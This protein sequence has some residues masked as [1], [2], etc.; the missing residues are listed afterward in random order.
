MSE[1]PV[2]ALQVAS[3]CEHLLLLEFSLTHVSEAWRVDILAKGQYTCFVEV[4]VVSVSIYRYDRSEK[5]A[6]ERQKCM[7]SLMW[8]QA[9]KLSNKVNSSDSAIDTLSDQE[10]KIP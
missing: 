4:K 7:Y 6:F 2:V 9:S 5:S 3:K 10:Q 8:M 1:K